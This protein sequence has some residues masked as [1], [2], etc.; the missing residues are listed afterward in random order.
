MLTL[1]VDL[2]RLS[3]RPKFK[4]LDGEKVREGFLQHGEF[5]TIV[6]NLPAYLKDFISFLYYGGWR[7]GAARNLQ[8]KD[9]DLET[10]TARLAIK[11]SKNKEPW[12]LPLAGTLWEIIERRLNERQLDCPYVFH[13]RNGR[14]IGDFRKKWAKACEAAGLVGII[15]HDLR[16][17]AAR[18]LSLSGVKEQLAMRITGHKTNS[19]YRRYRIVDEDELRQAQEQQ[20]AFLKNQTTARKVVPLRTGT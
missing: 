13:Y 18:N 6:D 17:C 4:Q 3:W 2:K 10:M 1:A 19:M 11:S 15:P 14:K 16:R 8:W 12:I 20:Q 9:I 5:L 7:K